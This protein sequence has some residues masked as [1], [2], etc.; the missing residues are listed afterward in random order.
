MTSEANS[1]HKNETRAFADRIADKRDSWIELNSFYYEADFR[2][3]RFLASE[4]LR[5]L[6]LGCGT[7]RLLH[8]LR[9]SYGVG[10]DFSPRMIEVAKKNYP[11]LNFHVGDIESPDFL[12]TLEGPFD[13]IVLS[14]TLGHLEDCMAVLDNLHQ[15]CGPKTRIIIA[16][17]SPI[18]EP[19]LKL[20]QWIGRRMPEKEMNWLSLSDIVR[21]L[22]ISD[23]QFIKSE[24][25]Q[26]FPLRLFGLGSFINWVFAPLP[27]IRRLCLRD[28]VVARSLHHKEFEEPSS[29]VV[30]PCRNEKGNIE[31]AVRTMPLFCKD[32]EIIF[33]EGHSQDGT[34]EE[35]LR[36][37]EAYPDYDIKCFQQTGKGKADAVWL[38]F[39]KARGDIL[40]ILDADLTVPP[41]NLS[42]F[43][44]V[45][46]D[47]KCEFLNGTRLIY[48][49][50][51]DAMRFLNYWANNAFAVIFSFLLNQTFTDTLCGT[52]V[53][54][55]STYNEIV[56]NRA[57]FGDFDP[58]GDFDLIF[59]AAK[60]NKKILE[61]PIRYASRSYGSTQIS[62]FSD[63][64]LLLKMVWFALFKF[65]VF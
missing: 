5:V 39:D 11:D 34:W 54:S 42:K 24:W 60:L 12:A 13:V 58:F 27:L 6:D 21:L 35:V 48:P 38:G 53:M 15:L 30:I 51:D 9:P 19:I 29:T 3:M 28:Y 50:D 44:N 36:V 52:K 63:G 18:W 47:G 4:G 2:Y 41:E 20:G 23:F 57:F 55:R 32:L 1:S 43:Y 8:E 61:V 33:V 25:R 37:K 46:A 22:E 14:D 45:I 65:K 10:V 59:G 64:W 7:G 31:T 62:R 56:K 16:Y 49:M 17:Y 26:L 40:M